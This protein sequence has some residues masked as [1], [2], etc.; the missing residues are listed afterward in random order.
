MH[1]T[2]VPINC[3]RKDL[4]L[5][6]LIDWTS[7]SLLDVY[8]SLESQ[9]GSGLGFWNYSHETIFRGSVQFEN[10]FTGE[11]VLTDTIFDQ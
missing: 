1:L 11:I 2:L 3:C 9:K 7:P 8:S 10:D 6:S 4:T 5:S